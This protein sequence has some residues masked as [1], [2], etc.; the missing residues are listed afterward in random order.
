MMGWR[1]VVWWSFAASGGA[2]AIVL[3]V[4]VVVGD[5]DTA[6]RL[7]SLVGAVAGVVALA[8]SVYAMLRT[9]APGS[10]PVRAQGGSNAAQGSIRNSSARETRPVPATPEGGGGISASG[11]SNDRVRPAARRRVTDFAAK[12]AM[13]ELPVEG[14]APSELADRMATCLTVFAAQDADLVRDAVTHNAQRL[15]T[16]TA[17]I[18]LRAAGRLGTLEAFWSGT[19]A[20]DPHGMPR[21]PGKRWP[22]SSMLS[23]APQRPTTL[24]WTRITATRSGS[25]PTPRHAQ[26]CRAWR[27]PSPPWRRPDAPE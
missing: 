24:S 12:H 27:R 22:A 9:P 17:G 25:L 7:A 26:P 2:A 3:T 4:L 14:I 21:S 11:G 10:P 16:A 5:L 20:C 1:W 13:L 15:L 18:Q 6:D 19:G 8:V 23:C